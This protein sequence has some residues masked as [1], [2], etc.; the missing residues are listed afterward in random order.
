[1]V[2]LELTFEGDMVRLRCRGLQTDIP[3]AA[4]PQA[5]FAPVLSRVLLRLA[6]PGLRYVPT[7][8]GWKLKGQ[9]GGC[10]FTAALSRDGALRTLRV[11]ATGLQVVLTG[12]RFA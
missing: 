5:G 10:A 4:L 7:S 11:P 9:T 12:V 8:G 2:G 6:Q 1:L 3:A